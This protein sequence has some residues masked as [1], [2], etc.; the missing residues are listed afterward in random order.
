MNMHTPLHPGEHVRD[1]L[2]D[3]AGLSVTNA[4][5]KLGITRTALSRL[6]NCHTGI[7]PE[8]AVRLSK[9]LGN[10]ID[11]WINLQAQYNVWEISQH[12]D[13]IK[14]LPLSHAA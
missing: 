3:D 1:V 8:M 7:S 5:E 12:A 9:L 2:I 11:F 4:A 14:V 10:S 6:I 13:Q